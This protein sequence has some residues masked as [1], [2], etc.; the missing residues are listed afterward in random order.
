MTSPAC[1]WLPTISRNQSTLSTHPAVGIA[2]RLAAVLVC[3][4][5]W[6]CG[7]DPDEARFKLGELGYEFTPISFLQATDRNDHVA[8][9]L[10]GLAGMDP[11]TR[12]H[13][14]HINSLNIYGRDSTTEFKISEAFKDWF[15]SRYMRSSDVDTTALIVAAVLG[16]KETVEVLLRAGADPSGEDGRGRSALWWAV[17]RGHEEIVEMLLDPDAHLAEEESAKRLLTIAVSRGQADILELLLDEGGDE[18]VENNLNFTALVQAVRREGLETA[19]LLIEAGAVV[20]AQADEGKGNTA[21][22]AASSEGHVE[23]V[24]MLLDAGADP[25]LRKGDGATALIM[26]VSGGNVEIVRM[27]LDAGADLNVQN[28]EGDTALILAAGRYDDARVPMVKLLLGAGADPNLENNEGATALSLATGK[29]DLELV[30]L[31]LA[32]GADPNVQDGNGDAALMVAVQAIRSRYNAWTEPSESGEDF[33]GVVLALLG[34]G[35]DPNTKNSDGFTPFMKAVEQDELDFTKTLLDAGA[36]AN[37]QD[38]DGNTLLMKALASYASDASRRLLLDA[39]GNADNANLQN[40]GGYTA[41]MIAAGHGG[42]D[43]VGAL[44]EVGANPDLQDNEGKTALMVA[45]Y[46][47]D[48]DIVN[49]L[50]DAGADPSLEDAQGRTVTNY[51]HS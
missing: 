31:L 50:L 17:N 49:A 44:L 14:E 51:A 6:G 24:R 42:R 3:L 40:S 47:D 10:F 48:V 33:H 39:V 1:S 37:V 23:A 45:A 4:S 8:V 5:L 29:G 43:T 7:V 34:D 12:F 46:E 35:A 41:L 13:R 9:R 30:R 15:K 32:A 19:V 28:N 25:N 36:D 18:F 2:M 21:L 20:D 38:A 22:M 26:A 16:H 11:D 27:L